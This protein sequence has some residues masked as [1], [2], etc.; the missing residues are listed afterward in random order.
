MLK[1]HPPPEKR[2]GKAENHQE[3]VWVTVNLNINT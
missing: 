1:E 2:V 3:G